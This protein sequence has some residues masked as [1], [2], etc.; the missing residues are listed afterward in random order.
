MKKIYYATVL[1]LFFACNNNIEPLDPSFFEVEP[2]QD[3]VKIDIE[4]LESIDYTDVTVITVD[5]TATI[6]S[7]GI[8]KNPYTDNGIEDLPVLLIE[9]EEILLGYFPN[10]LKTNK[11]SVD[12]VLLFY[13][14]T[15]PELAI[16]GY[17]YEFVMREIKSSTDYLKIKELVTSNLNINKSPLD[18]DTF[19]NLVRNI[20]IQIKAV[21]SSETS[22]TKKGIGT[23][24]FT[25]DREGKVSWLD[26]APLFAALG[27]SIS[28]E[29]TGK[30][31]LPPKI[32]KNKSL[33]LSPGSIISWAFNEFFTDNNEVNVESLN[34]SEDGRYKVSFNNGNSS[35]SAL[36]DFVSKKN[37]RYV[38]SNL[39]GFVLPIAMKSLNV[40][41][42]CANS[43][44]EVV[45]GVYIKATQIVLEGKVPDSGDLIQQIY[46]L[47]EGSADILI[48]CMGPQSTP[49]VYL[50]VLTSSIAKRLAIAEDISTLLFLLRDYI[51][52]VIQ[53]DE[54]RYFSKGVSFGD[55]KEKDGPDSQSRY[56][57]DTDEEFVF[58]K[59]FE[60]LEIEYDVNRGITSSFKREEKWDKPTNL[61]FI[62]EVTTGD[63]DIT[64]N[65]Y[66]NE[67]QI[68]TDTE[69]VIEVKM[70]MGKK[71]SKIQL[72]PDFESF[73]FIG[74]ETIDLIPT[75]SISLSGNTD[76]GEVKVNTSKGQTIVIENKSDQVL[77][78]TS[79]DLPE[80][81]STPWTLMP[82]AAYES[83]S[84]LVV[85]EPTKAREYKG[86]I[87]ILN[88]VDDINNTIEVTGFGTDD[89]ITL[90][91]D[92]NFGDV[93][94]NPDTP[95][96]RVLT[97]SN[98]NLN[99][100]INVD[101]IV[102]P[103]GY[104]ATGWVNGGV[105]NPS[106]QKQIEITFNPTIPGSYD[107][108]IVIV[109]DV[110]QE[111]NKIEIK[112]NGIN[113][114][115]NIDGF[116]YGETNVN[117]CEPA[118]AD[119]VTPNCEMHTVLHERDVRLVSGTSGF[120]PQGLE[121]GGV[122][123]DFYTGTESIL[124]NKYDFDGTTLNIEIIT[125]SSG[126]YFNGRT[127]NFTGTINA[128]GDKFEGTYSMDMPGGIWGAYTE[129]TM[130]Y[131]K[132]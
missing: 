126:R 100:S 5:S 54:L 6:T 67:G 110:D 132:K 78:I 17:D 37:N 91:G 73:G 97:I 21:H 89:K 122:I 88:N 120:C 25:Y 106:V 109:N 98:Y 41:S 121:C 112:G 118:R 69:G 86:N 94:I 8:F 15:Y 60:E 35:D 11:V 80:G 124:R 75:K 95:P 84:I 49:G 63:V 22:K 68:N 14:L 107:N 65:Y 116:W 103:D 101:P 79:I 61:P 115:V 34:L 18:D 59:S 44:D 71:D 42:N 119:T 29:T 129:G 66:D 64:D 92:L 9:N 105:L 125:T 19:N 74:H 1:L 47:S 43:I 30:V 16:Q 27:I 2:E 53:G 130:T 58:S 7:D 127:F 23:F 81:Y 13:F 104:T 55:L 48:N 85:F 31:V 87:T 45:D 93:T 3:E 123:Y 52:S 51:G 113:D 82:I 76:F 40:D 77:N 62:L 10:T 128:A 83:E 131:T 108:L 72:Y 50:R 90:E 20:T 36:N 114:S 39:L 26:E 96:T 38:A 28:N 24:K 111:N 12:D 57:G 33:V 99:K 32:L 70:I 56:D 102:L 117:K 46:S 4:E